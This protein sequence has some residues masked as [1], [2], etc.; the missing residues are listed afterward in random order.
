MGRHSPVAPPCWLLWFVIF[1]QIRLILQWYQHQPLFVWL[2]TVVAVPIQLVDHDQH[3]F[4]FDVR[5]G[6]G[7]SWIGRADS[8]VA[9][10]PVADRGVVGKDNVCLSAF[11]L[12]LAHQSDVDQR[13][14][15][16]PAELNELLFGAVPI[17]DHSDEF[18]HLCLR[19]VVFSTTGIEL[20][21]VSTNRLYI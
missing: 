7:V 16:G 21:V 9:I 2:I 5:D 12:C 14:L 20:S 1:C 3:S 13:V 18:L 19:Q 15:V 17:R 11:S 8:E 6:G 10:P 4:A